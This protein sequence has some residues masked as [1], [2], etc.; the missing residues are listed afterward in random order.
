M[1]HKNTTFGLKKFGQCRHGAAMLVALACMTAAGCTNQQQPDIVVGPD[2]RL[3]PAHLQPNPAPPKVVQVRVPVFEPQLRALPASGANAQP[4]QTS[5]ALQ[6]I[7]R[8][9][10]WFHP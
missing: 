4:K 1:R 9:G 5:N 6:T 10:Q 3:V 7:A 8:A 2:T